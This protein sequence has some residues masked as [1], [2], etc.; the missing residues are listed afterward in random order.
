MFW[1]ARYCGKSNAGK[2]NAPGLPNIAGIS[3]LGGF[4]SREVQPSG[5]FFNTVLEEYRMLQVFDSQLH[6]IETM[7]FDA[8]RSSPIYGSSDAVMPASVES[9][10]ALYLGSPAHV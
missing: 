5:P 7:I 4:S 9:V 8:S 1:S 6:N 10:V 3:D 2:Y